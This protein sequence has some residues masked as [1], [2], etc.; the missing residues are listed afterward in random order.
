MTMFAE[1]VCRGD[2]ERAKSLLDRFEEL[3]DIK[4]P[5]SPNNLQANGFLMSWIGNCIFNFIVV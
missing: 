1:K 3:N 4:Q 5:M 2:M